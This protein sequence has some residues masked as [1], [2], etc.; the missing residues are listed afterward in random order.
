VFQLR[1]PGID[2]IYVIISFPSYSLPVTATVL[3]KLLTDAEFTT[4]FLPS[5]T[6]VEGIMLTGKLTP[7]QCVHVNNLMQLQ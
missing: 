6:A 2:I 4:N 3:G 5:V 7:Y 1:V